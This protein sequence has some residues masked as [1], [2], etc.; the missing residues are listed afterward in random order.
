MI[1]APMRPLYNTVVPSFS[2]MDN[3]KAPNPIGAM[4]SM[5]VV[6][7]VY[8]PEDMYGFAGYNIA[9][10]TMAQAV[11]N[12]TAIQR[13]IDSMPDSGGTIL[14]SGMLQ[15]YGTITNPQRAFTPQIPVRPIPFSIVG[16]PG[17]DAT[18]VNLEVSPAIQIDNGYSFQVPSTVAKRRLDGLTIISRGKGV[19]VNGGGKSTELNNLIIA[20]CAD[21]GLEVSGWDGGFATNIYCINNKV[22]GAIFTNCHQCFVSITTRVNKRH[23]LSLKDCGSWQLWCDAEQ[24]GGY[25][26]KC[27]NSKFITGVVWQEANNGSVDNQG[28]PSGQNLPQGYLE[29]SECSFTGTM[30]QDNNLAFEYADTF[31]FLATKIRGRIPDAD[32]APYRLPL[33]FPKDHIQAPHPVPTIVS[34]PDEAGSTTGNIVFTI[35]AGSISAQNADVTSN[36]IEL[37]SSAWYPDLLTNVTINAGE[38]YIFRLKFQASQ[39]CLDFYTST[40]KATQTPTIVFN[41]T[42]PA[43][44]D[45]QS[46]HL[47]DLRESVLEVQCRATIT[48]TGDIR[49]FL[50]FYRKILS[51]TQPAVPHTITLKSI[52]IYKLPA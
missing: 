9:N 11:A 19:V 39:D 15:Y 49:N 38:V 40:W 18:L 37:Y 21:T 43:M 12:R 45:G 26:L 13:I 46:F 10:I 51:G 44:G 33:P 20:Y 17:T 27:I 42:H 48:A 36:W 14:I 30:A 34:T 7:P 4:Q 50:Y 32:L 24:N 35:G 23:G 25:G 8:R 31:S 41:V 6:S 16:A 3:Q 22:D 1:S 47:H 28:V 5:N 52:D 2:I 29:Y